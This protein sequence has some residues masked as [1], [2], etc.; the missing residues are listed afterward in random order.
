MKSWL[1][2]FIVFICC[3]TPA[4]ALDLDQLRA[5]LKPL[6][7]S[8]PYEPTPAVAEYFNFYNLSPADAGHWF[9]TVA[10]E[11]EILAAHF[12]LPKNPVG[13]IF[14]VHG[15][16]DHTATLSKLI[17]EGIARNYAVVSW[18]LPGHGL[19]SGERTETGDFALCAAQLEDIL[20]RVKGRLP[21]PVHLMAHSTGASIAMEYLHNAE[22][23]QFDRIVLLAPLVRHAHWG[24]GKFGYTI[25]SPFTNH[26]GRKV[27]TNSS[28]PVYLEFARNDPLGIES[29]SYEYLEDLY[30]WE[31]RAR[32]YPEWDGAALIIQGDLDDVVDW[33]Y[34]LEF[35]QGKMPEAEISIIPGARHQLANES[36]AYRIQVFD[37][38]F[39]WL[40]KQTR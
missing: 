24:W 7:V 13:T 38:A 30:E 36:D 2:N 17:H 34:N 14:L 15:F 12:F 19:T 10:S 22:I 27:K 8:I 21:Q 20:G 4:V 40:S 26:I 32:D 28:N 16:L 29:I 35:L 5:D 39:G 37:L 31:E 11:G 1:I 18:D 23:N 25:S 9:G 3:S 6:D 33:E